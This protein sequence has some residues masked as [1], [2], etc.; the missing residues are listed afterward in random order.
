MIAASHQKLLERSR[1]MFPGIERVSI[2][3]RLFLEVNGMGMKLDK[4]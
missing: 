2:R 1:L 3:L 4:I